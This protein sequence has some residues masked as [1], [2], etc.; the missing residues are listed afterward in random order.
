MFLH[1]CLFK[2][3]SVTYT[4]VCKLPGAPTAARRSVRHHAIRCRTQKM[5]CRETLGLSGRAAV[6]V[7]GLFVW[8][9]K[10]RLPYRYSGPLR[11]TWP[12][13]DPIPSWLLC[14]F[15]SKT[16]WFDTICCEFKER[17]R[18]KKQEGRYRTRANIKL[19][20]TQR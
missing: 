18:V 11:T 2:L 1:V 4:H 17:E 8:R 14:S 13:E 15:A 6:C 10:H 12:D 7:E 3:Q 9:S 20:N 19:F 5:E 16:H